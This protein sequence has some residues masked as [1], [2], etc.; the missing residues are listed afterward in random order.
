MSS[1][2]GEAADAKPICGQLPGSIP[3]EDGHRPGTRS[4]GFSPTWTV[5]VQPAHYNRLPGGILRAQSGTWGD[6]KVH[7]DQRG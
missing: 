1:P 6:D 7:G 5:R 4:L 2:H 3:L